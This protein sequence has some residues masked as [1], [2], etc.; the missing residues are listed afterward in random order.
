ML[1]QLQ[2]Q[3]LVFEIFYFK[4]QT[5]RMKFDNNTNI[6][7]LEFTIDPSIMQPTEIYLNEFL[8]YPNGFNTA[9]IPNHALHVS[10]TEPNRLQLISTTNEV[11]DV[12]FVI[13]PL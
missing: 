11:T 13:I 1:M 10:Q 12:S 8:H 7:E 2:V 4:G 5:K 9:V 3:K 6:F